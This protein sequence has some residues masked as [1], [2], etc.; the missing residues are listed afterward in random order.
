M[1]GGLEAYGSDESD[2]DSPVHIEDS[3]TA[4]EKTITSESLLSLPPP[5]NS[6]KARPKRAIFTVTKPT[7]NLGLDKDEENEEAKRVT[8]K[9]KLG[10]KTSAGSSSLLAM[11]PAPT[12]TTLPVTSKA[13][14]GNLLA[15][16]DVE[17]RHAEESAESHSKTLLIPVQ[18]LKNTPNH[19]SHQ[20]KPSVDF[21]SLGSS[22]FHNPLPYIEKKLNRVN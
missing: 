5:V 6:A 14:K 7:K 18:S 4:R 11:L 19:K 13:S 3:S 9:L 22:Q 2:S 20:S 16:T 17:E 8:K 10:P 21:F 15:T 1:L 12:K